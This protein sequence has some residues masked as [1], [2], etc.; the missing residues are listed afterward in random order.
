MGS[1]AEEP[2]IN[3]WGVTGIGKTWFLHHVQH[4]YTY[5]TVSEYPHPTLGYPTFV[6]LYVFPYNSAIPVLEHIAR[7]FAD[8]ALSQLAS[9]LSAE[10]QLRLVRARDLGSPEAL[11]SELLVLSRRF[12]PLILLDQA[13]NMGPVD[14]EEMER[15][16]IEPLVSSGRVLIIVGGRR[17]IARWRRFEVR[18]RVME[19]E[20]CRMRPFDKQM[21]TRQLN[22][23]QYSIPADSLFPFTG[24]NPHLIDVI[25]Q[26]VTVWIKQGPSPVLDPAWFAHH[27]QDLLQIVYESELQLLKNVPTGLR[28]ILDTVSPLRFYRSEALRAMLTVREVGALRQSE[29]YYLNIL[30]VLDQDT[31][32]V[33]WDRTRRAYTMSEVVRRIINC[34]HL[35]ENAY[36][37]AT[38][39]HRALMMYWGWVN[40]YPEISEDFIVE[41]WFHL[42]CLYS[43]NSD[44]ERLRTEA[45]HT[46]AFA[47]AHLNAN[48]LLNLENQL[49]KDPDLLELLSQTLLME[50]L[51]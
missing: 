17:Q 4:L 32:L 20:K 13:E 14:W 2:I 46:L 44:I 35:L 34:R 49:Q 12:V 30:H 43:A 15:Q 42:A 33:W 50:L 47:R 28:P 8:E 48:R 5:R 1:T 41:I 24:G 16:L 27:Q 45:Q 29:A 11:I 37:Y 38:R 7:A 26:Q 40:Q 51:L 31:E 22:Q 36:D 18:R 39:H 9:A 21:M 23:Y 3:F 6:L 19:P 25:A 10:E